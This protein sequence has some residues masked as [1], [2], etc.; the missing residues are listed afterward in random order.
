MFIALCSGAPGVSTARRDDARPKGL[1]EAAWPPSPAPGMSHGSGDGKSRVV[2]F[3]AAKGGRCSQIAIVVQCQR[4]LVISPGVFNQREQRKFYPWDLTGASK[5]SSL[6][7]VRGVDVGSAGDGIPFFK[8]IVLFIYSVYFGLCWIFAAA[9]LGFSRHERG[10]LSAAESGL[11]T[12]MPSLGAAPRLWITGSLAVVPG[13]VS[14][15]SSWIRDL[16]S[17]SCTGRWILSQ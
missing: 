1:M 8:K 17:V 12:A 11:L 13:L 16:T 3:S 6:V 15:R 9:W 10:R 5:V 2:S 7:S 4:G 14:V